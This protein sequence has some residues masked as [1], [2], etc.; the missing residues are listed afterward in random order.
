ME[1]AELPEKRGMGKRVFVPEKNRQK[2]FG[3]IEWRKLITRL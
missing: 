1:S 2:N 3:A